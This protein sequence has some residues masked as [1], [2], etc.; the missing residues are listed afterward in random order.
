MVPH[1]KFYHGDRVIG[2]Q[3][4][5]TTD[6]IFMRAAEIYLLHAEASAKIGYEIP[7]KLT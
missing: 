6:Y 2:G 1:Y 3:R 7:Q 4:T 5:I